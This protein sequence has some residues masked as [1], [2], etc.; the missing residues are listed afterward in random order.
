M[1]SRKRAAPSQEVTTVDASPVNNPATLEVVIPPP[2]IRPSK[3]LPI[4]DGNVIAAT[5][6]NGTSTHGIFLPG[7]SGGMN[8]VTTPSPRNGNSE[9]VV[10]QKVLQRNVDAMLITPESS[11]AVAASPMHNDLLTSTK[12]QSSISPTSVYQD[13]TDTMSPE[14]AETE[15]DFDG[16]LSHFLSDLRNEMDLLEKGDVDILD[17][18]VDLS[19][20]FALTLSNRSEVLDLLDGVEEANLEADALIR[21]MTQF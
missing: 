9:S 6:P 14:T 5:T 4:Q 19:Q 1:F 7:L 10:G 17:L 2:R 12:N 11:N 20:A 15:D 3:P 8:K 16:L 13:N 21:E 18:E